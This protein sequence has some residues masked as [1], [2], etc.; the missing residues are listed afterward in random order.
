MDG[1]V[2]LSAR[3][4]LFDRIRPLRQKPFQRTQHLLRRLALAGALDPGN[5][6]F[7]FARGFDDAV[8]LAFRLSARVELRIAPATPTPRARLAPADG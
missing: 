6:E 8:P 3:I 5:D 4:G 7:R 1:A 2:L